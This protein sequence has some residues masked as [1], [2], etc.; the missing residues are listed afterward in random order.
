MQALSRNN[1]PLPNLG[2]K[3][4]LFYSLLLITGLTLF[5]GSWLHVINSVYF[6][7]GLEEGESFLG[8]ALGVLA[9]KDQDMFQ[10]VALT[11]AT[12]LVLLLCVS[13]FLFRKTSIR[14]RVKLLLTSAAIILAILDVSA[15]YKAPT[16]S[17]TNLYVGILG[18]S[19]GIPLIF[20]AAYPLYQMWIFKRWHS[21]DG[22]KKR[23][24]I[25]GGGFAGLYAAMGLNKRLGYH[26]D[27]EITLVDKK[28]YFLFPPLLPSA[29]AGT[30]ETRQVSYPFRRI[31]ETTNII[32]RKCA[33][34]SIEPA[35]NIVNGVLEVNE[36]PKSGEKLERSVAFEYDY[37]ILAPGSITQTFGTKGAAQH[38]FFMRELSDAVALRNQVIDLF[39]KA[40]ALSN[41]EEKRELLRFVIVGAGPTGIETA[42][43]IYDLIHHVLL[44]RYP[45][46]ETDTPEVCIVQSGEQVLPGWPKDIVQMTLRQ[47]SKM[48]IKLFLKSRVA[49]V[50]ANFVSLGKDGQPLY[51]RTIVWCAGVKPSELLSKS[52]LPLH[53]SGRVPVK[54]DLTVETSPN[55]MVLGDAAYLVDKKSN[56]ALPPLG[57]VA[58]QQGSH[59]AKN[60]VRL[61][62]SKDTKSFSYFNFGGLVSVGEHFAAVNLLGIKFSGFI[63][64]LIWRS[65]YL[66]KLVGVSNKIRVVIDWTLDLLIER[67]ISQIGDNDEE[68]AIQSLQTSTVKSA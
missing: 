66:A 4:K 52:G 15:W 1:I 11:H 50:G 53:S 68:Y 8:I 36:D 55:V 21:P 12:S 42:T 58:F 45:E 48:N 10:M 57:Q 41:V 32:F 62:S 28:N 65:L 20:L 5:I 61:L 60:I 3:Q 49:E 14:R 33:V 37:L 23:V 35:K 27:L 67:S 25:V 47:L 30:I 56:Q 17:S 43:E 44:K 2:I 38:A 18:L 29:A 9:S 59:A 46:I 34:S 39:E 7:S 51:A 16:C 13:Y 64:W 54:N 22:K 63:G 26:P 31:F 40:A 19:A 24:V 6:D